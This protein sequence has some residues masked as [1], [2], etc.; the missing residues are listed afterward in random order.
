MKKINQNDKKMINAG[1]KSSFTANKGFFSI[2]LAGIC[3]GNII[4][5][6]STLA[7]NSILESKGYE[8]DYSYNTPTAKMTTNGNYSS[9][10]L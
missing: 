8:V 7:A 1:K 5:S 9:F 6:F 2:A 10:Y 3:I 4:D